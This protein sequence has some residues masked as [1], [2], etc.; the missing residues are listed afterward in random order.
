MRVLIDTNIILDFVL[1]RQPFYPEANE[2]L[3]HLKNQKFDG[4]VSPITPINVFYVT[5]KEKD[6]DTAFIAVEELLNLSEI[7]I[8]G[9]QVVQD[10][11]SLGFSDYEDA[12]QCSA[13]MAENL[14]GIVTRDTKD[15]NNSPIRVF[16]PVEFLESLEA[17]G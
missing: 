7:A 9:R 8:S 1:A 3:F 14:D 13:A 5:R 6:T 10:A 12:V 11:L 2:I 17:E 15:F 4:Y 16:T